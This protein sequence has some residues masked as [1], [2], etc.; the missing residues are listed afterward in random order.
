MLRRRMT[1][2]AGLCLLTLTCLWAVGCS[3][4]AVESEP[5]PYLTV[6]PASFELE[7]PYGGPSPLSVFAHIDCTTGDSLEFTFNETSSWMGLLNEDR[8]KEGITPD[9]FLIDFFVWKGA[10]TLPVGD[11]ADTIWID[12]P[13]AANSPQRIVILISISGKMRVVPARLSYLTSMLGDPPPTQTI[14]VTSLDGGPYFYNL[15]KSA[16]WLNLDDRSGLA[17]DTIT[18]RIDAGG[19]AS[20]SYLDTI[21]FSADNISGSPQIVVCSLSVSPWLSQMTAYNQALQDVF[22]VDELHGWAVGFLP[23][24]SRNGYIFRTLDGGVTWDLNQYLPGENTALSS[25]T[26]INNTGWVVGENGIILHTID[27]GDNWT[28]QSTGLA[29]TTVALNDVAFVS[30]DTGWIV[31][32]DGIILKTTN[33]GV[34]WILQ[35]SGTGYDLISVMFVDDQYG[36]AVGNANAI[37]HTD[38][39]GQTWH[40]QTAGY[41]DFRGVHFVDRN[42]GWVVGKLGTIAHT[43]NGGADWAPQS[44]QPITF[45]PNLRSVFFID[46]LTGWVVGES[47][48]ILQTLDGGQSWSQQ[49]SDTEEWL[50]GVHFVN[51]SVGWVVGD[52]GVIR[53]TTSGGN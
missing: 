42:I 51:S 43:S 1:G 52:K 4:K 5:V 13:D 16:S 39:G 18:V 12:A 33:G 26:F 20:G 48:I 3:E 36:W 19:L 50:F 8:T 34:N 32:D 31:G 53:H 23:G 47:G 46:A 38:D 35:T 28:Y 14:L 10:D 27:G 11:H 29:D 44:I 7:A 21:T 41:F 15:E 2:A 17:P 24:T 37:V 30:T 40:E 25:I 6:E 45:Q 22:F 49:Y 9:S